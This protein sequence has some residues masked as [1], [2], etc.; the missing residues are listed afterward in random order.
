MQFSFIFDYFYEKQSIFYGSAWTWN[1]E[2]QQFYY[3][4]FAKEQP[5]LNYRNPRVVQ[6]MKDVLRF[7]LEKG[8]GGFRID[9]INFLYEVED[10]RDEPLSGWTD[11]PNSYA[12]THH[13][14]TKDLVSN[15]IEAIRYVYQI[16][17]FFL[18][19]VFFRMKF[20]I[21]F[22]NGVN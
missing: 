19:S 2:R 20:T 6:E 10:F 9:A 11:D 4:N 13:D 22:I 14:Y 16:S 8:A 15:L 7:W 12:Y 21:W 17:N 18:F 1:E 3:H 5:D